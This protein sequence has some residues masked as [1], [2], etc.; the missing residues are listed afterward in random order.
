MVLGRQ[1]P[2]VLREL[3]AMEPNDVHPL[4]IM[5]TNTWHLA[6]MLMGGGE[7]VAIQGLKFALCFERKN[8][9]TKKSFNVNTI[10]QN[11]P[12]HVNVKLCHVRV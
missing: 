6:H 1:S 9:L 4:F 10:K 12:K 3:L 11:H 5:E 8:H 2:K 7:I